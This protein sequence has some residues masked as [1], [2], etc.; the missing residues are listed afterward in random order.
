V[1]RIALRLALG[2]VSDI[3]LASQRV[4]PKVAENS[5]YVFEHPDLAGALDDV[6]TSMAQ[7]STA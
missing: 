1:P 5:G 6:M 4:F 3:L 2:E 7:S